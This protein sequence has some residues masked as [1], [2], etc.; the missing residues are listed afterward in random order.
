[1]MLLLAFFVLMMTPTATTLAAAASP[2]H[3]VWNNLHA[4]HLS[5]NLVEGFAYGVP[6]HDANY[7]STVK[8]AL[9]AALF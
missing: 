4:A 9:R 3:I 8:R 5:L 7:I 2:S 6:F 1:M